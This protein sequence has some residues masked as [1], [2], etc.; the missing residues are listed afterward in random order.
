[1]DLVGAG[2]GGVANDLFTLIVLSCAYKFLSVLLT[3]KIIQYHVSATVYLFQ[4]E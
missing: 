3:V 1:M 4:P 2:D